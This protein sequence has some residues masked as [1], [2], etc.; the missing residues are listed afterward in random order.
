MTP[1]GI[2]STR[3][4]MA[5]VVAGNP[6]SSANERRFLDGSRR[7]VVVLESA[8]VGRGEYL[9]GWRWSEH[10][11]K[12]TAKPSQAHIGYV[13]SG[14]MRI[15]SADGEETVVHPG[16]AFEVGA[17]HD[18]WVVGDTPC[19]ALDFEHVGPPHRSITE[20]WKG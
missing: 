14:Q 1:G 17:G 15:Q 16:E 12:Q 2:R 13:L 9:P 19:V 8:T 11:G 20:E 5:N 10:A 4:Q 3:L 7:G 6:E 18:A